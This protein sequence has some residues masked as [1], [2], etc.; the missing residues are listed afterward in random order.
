MGGRFITGSGKRSGMAQLNACAT[1]GVGQRASRMS[2]KMRILVS[3]RYTLK[4]Q[5]AFTIKT[6]VKAA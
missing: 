5:K 2:V 6:L 3:I 4:N 1:A